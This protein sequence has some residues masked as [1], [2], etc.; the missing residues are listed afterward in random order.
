M[1]T[2]KGLKTLKKI[3]SWV[4]KQKKGHIFKMVQPYHCVLGQ[5]TEAKKLSFG[6]SIQFPNDDDRAIIRDLFAYDSLSWNA[7]NPPPLYKRKVTREK[8]LK[9]CKKLI[10][11]FNKEPVEA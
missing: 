8:W 4:K 5:Y 6:I 9:E 1:L 3:R 7:H 2:K 11:S 10:K